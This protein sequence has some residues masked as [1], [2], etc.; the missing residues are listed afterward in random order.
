[1]RRDRSVECARCSLLRATLRERRFSVH[2]DAALEVGASETEIAA[3]REAATHLLG[4]P[5]ELL[6]DGDGFLF[7]G[8]KPTRARR[9]LPN[10]K[11]LEVPIV[12]TPIRILL[13]TARPDDDACRY[14][15]HRVSALPLVEAME[16]CPVW[17][18]SPSSA[19]LRSRH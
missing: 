6:H 2:V 1:M 4:L 11:V 5:W 13:V 18:K 7:Q 17:S 19:R 16:R 10:T 3:A 15:D 12:A 9:R 8:A 14:I